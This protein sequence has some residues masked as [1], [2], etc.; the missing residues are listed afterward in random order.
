[1]LKFNLPTNIFQKVR[2]FYL[3]F[4][5]Y[6]IKNKHNK[7][8]LEIRN[9]SKINVVFLLIHESVWKYE[10]VYNLMRD[11]KRFDPVV[12]VCPY[13]IYGEDNMFKTLNQTFESFQKKGY[14]VINTYDKEDKTWLNIKADLKP[15][16]VFFTNPHDL[17]RKEYFIDNFEDKLT[18]YV[19]YNFGNSHLYEMMYNQEF[20]NKIWK[21]YAETDIHKQY[22]ISYAENKGSNVVVTGYPTSDISLNYNYMTSYSWKIKSS[23]L[24]KVIWA[25]HHTIDDDISFLG[26]S[27]FLMYF[28]FFLEI[29]N[30]YKGEIQFAFK[31]HPLLLNKLYE[32]KEWGKDRTDEYYGKWDKLENAMFVLGSYEELF[33]TSDAMIHDCGSFLIEYLFLNKPVLHTNRDTNIKDRMNSFG[34]MAFEKHYHAKNEADIIYFLDMLINDEDS[35]RKERE[36]FIKDYLIPPNAISASTNIFKEIESEVYVKIEP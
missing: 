1:M 24:K 33:I 36:L 2:G 14:D 16:I 17:T 23:S 28:N 34:K 21:L 30:K 13:V 3:K 9:K 7:A 25:P 19:P 31:P 11:D 10:G 20:H 18:C 29:A 27:S 5:Y 35:K 26:Y 22:S 6:S 4:K 12:V 8:L 32:L 15:D